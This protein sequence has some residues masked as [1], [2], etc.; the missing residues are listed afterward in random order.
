METG[1]RNLL[2]TKTSYCLSGFSENKDENINFFQNVKILII[3][4]GGLGCELIKCVAISGIKNIDI[5]D[6]DVIEI[7]NLNRQ[8]LFREKDIGK[9]KSEVAAEF[10]RRRFPSCNIV[11]HTK[12]VQEMDDDFY[13]NFDLVL[14][15][16]D[17]MEARI[18]INQKL[19]EL[20]MTRGKTIFYIDGAV[21]GFR[22]QI[23]FITPGQPG[24]MSCVAQNVPSI[25][26][27]QMCTLANKPRLPEHCVM[28]AKE[29]WIIN[30]P[31]IEFDIDNMEHL[32]MITKD[33]KDHAD[34][35]GLSG[36]D[37][38]FV[39]R[40][41]K[42][43]IPAIASTQAMIASVCVTEAIKCISE[44]APCVNNRVDFN[45]E[46]GFCVDSFNFSSKDCDLCYPK[47]LDEIEMSSTVSLSEA[48][49]VFKSLMNVKHI[50]FVLSNSTLVFM[51]SNEQTHANLSK[52]LKELIEPKNTVS[53]TGENK[54][55]SYHIRFI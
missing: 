50:S 34:K 8:Y 16:L 6:M 48:I 36:I 19:V 14:G 29:K 28:Y 25:Q 1:I 35:F 13:Y 47:L 3:G 43:T 41:I 51:D 18:W 2:T 15:G 27:Y 24:C 9:Y 45:S 5:I 21:E 22:G 33:A 26:R 31:D 55:Q 17:N 10:I 46:S 49:V 30:H 38:S 4:A 12:R 23:M 20:K 40:V 52:T 42:N 39:T 32:E 53:L 54:K 11:S 37:S 44:C 7:S